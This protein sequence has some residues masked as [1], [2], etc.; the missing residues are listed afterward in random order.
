MFYII[1]LD[2]SDKH[3]TV[4]KGNAIPDWTGTILET[5]SPKVLTTQKERIV[6][7]IVKKKK[8]NK[9]RLQQCL[10]PRQ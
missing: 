10:K 5:Q 8:S 7:L 2:K 9:I 6:F 4:L 1:Y 3:L